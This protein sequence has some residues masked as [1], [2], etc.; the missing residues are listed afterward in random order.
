MV[1]LFNLFIHSFIFQNLNGFVLNLFLSSREK[2]AVGLKCPCTWWAPQLQPWC[3]ERR[4][5]T[6]SLE[7]T[8]CFCRGTVVRRR[9]FL[10]SGGN[11]TK[12]KQQQQRKTCFSSHFIHAKM[13]V[14]SVLLFLRF[15][16]FSWMDT[17][18]VWI[19]YAVF[20]SYY[21]FAEVLTSLRGDG[22]ETMRRTVLKLQLIWMF[23]FIHELV[24]DLWSDN[25]QAAVR[26]L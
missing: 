22:S 24:P 20:L 4:K 17:P 25:T 15:L 18:Q 11:K 2:R 19:F 26:Y 13:L 6:L 5:V 9:L 1:G 21:A 10:W 16:G 3:A 12:K 23:Y 8:N 7:N 14:F